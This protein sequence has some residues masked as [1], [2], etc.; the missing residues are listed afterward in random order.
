MN[1][2]KVNN[3]ESDTH[4]SKLWENPDFWDQYGLTEDYEIRLQ[5]VLEMTPPRLGKVVDIGCGRGEVLDAIQADKKIGLDLSETALSYIKSTNVTTI[6][7]DVRKM[8]K[9]LFGADVDLLIALEVFEHFPQD[10]FELIVDQI[11]QIVPR[12]VL[13]GVPYKEIL[14]KRNFNCP[15]CGRTFNADTHHLSFADSTLLIQS[16]GGDYKLVD[17]RHI[18]LKQARVPG[19]FYKI[20]NRFAN[21]EKHCVCW[22]CGY[23]GYRPRKMILQKQCLFALRCLESALARLVKWQPTWMLV[24]LERNED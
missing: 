7:A 2:S 15:N 10:E 22:H 19:A 20:K 11:R 13:L 21:P 4:L 16:F 3:R 17:E 18:G 9:L 14:E 12:Y 1:A 6:V 23:T 8:P 5:T 24:L